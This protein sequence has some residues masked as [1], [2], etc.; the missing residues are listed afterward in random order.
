MIKVS[1]LPKKDPVEIAKPEKT[2][3]MHLNYCKTT[4]KCGIFAA[5]SSMLCNNFH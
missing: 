3:K 5:N 2:I 4:L 1:L